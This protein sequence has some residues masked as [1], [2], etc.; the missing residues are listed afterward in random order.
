[1]MLQV[2]LIVALAYCALKCFSY[3]IGCYA[4]TMFFLEHGAKEPDDKEIE[5][6]RQKVLE[7]M[8]RDI[9]HNLR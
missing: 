6:Y 7:N 1:M 2:L 9:F 8:A 5:A 4:L 3:K